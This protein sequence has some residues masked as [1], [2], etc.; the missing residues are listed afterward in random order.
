[1]ADVDIHHQTDSAV[2]VIVVVAMELPAVLN[3]VVGVQLTYYV[4]NHQL[5]I[6]NEF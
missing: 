2:I 1:M 3:I 4:L 6:T 5:G